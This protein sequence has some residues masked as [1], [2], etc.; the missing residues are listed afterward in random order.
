MAETT[1]WETMVNPAARTKGDP[2]Y[3]VREPDGWPV[4][5]VWRERD[6]ALVAAAPDLLDA[7]RALD[8]LDCCLG[9]VFPGSDWPKLWAA[10][11]AARAAIAK[12]TRPVTPT[13]PVERRAER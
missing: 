1:R 7:C 3:Q 9:Y 10:L 8:E 2:K 11:D 5:L 13:N 4:A 12:A 6:L